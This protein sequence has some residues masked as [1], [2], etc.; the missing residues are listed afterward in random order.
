MITILL[1]SVRNVLRKHAHS[2]PLRTTRSEQRWPRTILT[3]G[4]VY[5]YIQYI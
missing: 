4:N 1:R 5:L 3:T 2:L